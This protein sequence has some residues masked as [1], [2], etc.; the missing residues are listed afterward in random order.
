MLTTRANPADAQPVLRGLLYFGLF[1]LIVSGAIVGA[2][3]LGWIDDE[4][5]AATRMVRSAGTAAEVD[6]ALDQGDRRFIRTDS[7]TD[8]WP[9]TIKAVATR[10]GSR[11]ASSTTSEPRAYNEKLLTRLLEVERATIDALEKRLSVDPDQLQSFNDDWSIL[12]VSPSVKLDLELFALERP[13]G[14]DWWRS[15][16]RSW[17]LVLL[18][19]Q[20]RALEFELEMR[21]TGVIPSRRHALL[22]ETAAEI[23][24][25]AETYDRLSPQAAVTAE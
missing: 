6:A 13:F 12:V 17:Q 4:V 3:Q 2:W 14:S 21:E 10:Y 25:A 16:A 24:E 19:D 7:D 5:A 8:P 22:Q 20:H 11:P 15:A 1:L 18:H 9:G 23:A